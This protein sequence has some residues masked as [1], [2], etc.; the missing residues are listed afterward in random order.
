MRRFYF[1]KLVRDKVVANCIDDPTVLHVQY[2][3]LDDAAYR[4][5]LIAKAAEEAAEIPEGDVDRAEVLAELADLQNVVDAL[6][7]S[8]GFTEAE[9][10]A[11]A[12]AKTLK[13][14]AFEL[15]QYIEYVDLADDSAWVGIFRKQPDKYREE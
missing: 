14:G 3:T 10:R 7:D 11:A 9:V 6:R 2:K 12:D 13:K 1:E 15:R 4:R 5:A 8:A